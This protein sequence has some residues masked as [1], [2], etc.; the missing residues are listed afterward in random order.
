MNML[1]NRCMNDKV[2]QPNTCN[3]KFMDNLDDDECWWWCECVR[4]KSKRKWI[5]CLMVCICSYASY[6]FHSMNKNE[7]VPLDVSKWSLNIDV[8]T[9]T[10]ISALMFDTR[11]RFVDGSRESRHQRFIDIGLYRFDVIRILMHG[12]TAEMKQSVIIIIIYL[13]IPPGS[14][15]NYNLFISFLLCH[16]NTYAHVQIHT[17]EI[18]EANL[19]RNLC[20]NHKITNQLHVYVS[21]IRIAH[22]SRQSTFEN[23]SN[24]RTALASGIAL[25][26]M[27][28][29][30]TPKLV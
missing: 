22:S 2:H 5:E 6:A 3:N 18:P 25:P 9:Q 20:H 23:W 4:W 30:L 14:L 16:A 15:C 26:Y 11:I 8:P 13:I 19:C 10:E 27:C 29:D 17:P 1:C 28:G 24:R 7:I 21:V 12:N